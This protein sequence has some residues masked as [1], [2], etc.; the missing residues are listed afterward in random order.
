MRK[1]LVGVIVGA[2]L[3]SVLGFVGT[4]S[5]EVLRERR[6]REEDKRLIAGALATELRS[7]LR[8][9]AALQKTGADGPVLALEETYFSVFD[10]AGSRL[11]LL[12]GDLPV[13]TVDCYLKM[14]L[15]LDRM[16]SITGAFELAL[17]LAGDD[18]NKQA[19][20]RADAMERLTKEVRVLGDL[21]K[22]LDDLAKKL[23]AVARES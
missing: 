1:T 19:R 22:Q 3:G 6:Q 18:E 8:W 15:A 16:R 2:V 11:Y 4:H 7:Q 12:P 13:A 17:P 10:G 21:S 5:L 9:W 23:E 14:K 20:I